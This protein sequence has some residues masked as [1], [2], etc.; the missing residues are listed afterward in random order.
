[1]AANPKS[2]S[3]PVPTVKLLIDGKLVESTAREWREVVNPATQEVLA[4]V[5]MCGADEVDRA[6]KSAAFGSSR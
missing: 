1:M 3:H 4:R 5:P 6:V 2:A